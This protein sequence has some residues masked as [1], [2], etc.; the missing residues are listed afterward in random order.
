MQLQSKVTDKSVTIIVNNKV[1]KLN[2]RPNETLLELLR[3]KINIKSVKAACWSGDCGICTV[4]IEDKPIK[5]CLVLACE[6]NNKRITTIEGLNDQIKTIQE[7]FVKHGAVQCGFCSPGFLV[8]SYYLTRNRPSLT[9]LE[10]KKSLNG[11]IC[12]CT[13]YQQIIDS[14]FSLVKATEKV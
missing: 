6:V 2:V 14:I 3:N 8:M 10:I 4:L 13:G 12:R 11:I 5:S 9:K 7:A 1:F